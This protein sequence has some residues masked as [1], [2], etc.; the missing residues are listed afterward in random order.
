MEVCYK[1]GRKADYICPDCSTKMCRAH[2]EP[3]YAGP[4]R[5]FRSRHMCPK[6]WR[7]KHRVLNEEMVNAH[8]YKAKVYS[9]I[10]R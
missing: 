5:G 10:K 9:Y 6:C 7:T 2:T 1:C 3:R 8:Q 4:D